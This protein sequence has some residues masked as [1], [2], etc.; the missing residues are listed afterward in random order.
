MFIYFLFSPAENK[1][2]KEVFKEFLF[3]EFLRT[4]VRVCRNN[5]STVE[6]FVGEEKEIKENNL[7]MWAMVPRL[8]ANTIL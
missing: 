8:M 2:F 5:T 7:I 6:L 1:K 4:W 3:S